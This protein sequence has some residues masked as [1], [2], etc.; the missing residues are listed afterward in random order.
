[1]S[2]Q[3]LFSHKP[4]SEKYWFVCGFSKVLVRL[5]RRELANVVGFD[6]INLGGCIYTI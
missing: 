3:V 5:V 2:A 6:H 4:N 1:M